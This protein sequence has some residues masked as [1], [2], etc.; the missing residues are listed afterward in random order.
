MRI[1]MKNL[2]GEELLLAAVLG[3]API[4]RRVNAELDRRALLGSLADS[5]PA[6]STPG[7]EGARDSL[8]VA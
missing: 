2:S 1:R 4:R 3:G 8:L 7:T 6:R 5:R